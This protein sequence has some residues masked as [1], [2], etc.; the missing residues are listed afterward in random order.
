MRSEPIS[1]DHDVY[2]SVT[3]NAGRNWYLLLIWSSGSLSL[4]SS[5]YRVVAQA[6]VGIILHYGVTRHL[7]GNNKFDRLTTRAQFVAYQTSM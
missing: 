6:V 7:F 4:T 5:S 1:L 3:T 2:Q